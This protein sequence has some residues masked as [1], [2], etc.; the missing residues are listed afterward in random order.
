M[1]KTTPIFTGT[2][3]MGLKKEKEKE[4]KEEAVIRRRRD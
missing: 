1:N 2:Q 4:E 3:Q